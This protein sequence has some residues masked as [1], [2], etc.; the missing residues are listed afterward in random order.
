[1]TIQEKLTAIA[2]GIPQ[3]YEAGSMISSFCGRRLRSR[4]GKLLAHGHTFGGKSGK[5]CGRDVPFA[6]G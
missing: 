2:V 5:R 3:V 6:P 4:E 1:M